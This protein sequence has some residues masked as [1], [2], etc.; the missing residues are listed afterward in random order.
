MNGVG[1]KQALNLQAHKLN[2]R[3]LQVGELLQLEVGVKSSISISVLLIRK[4]MMSILLYGGMR[5][6]VQA[7]IIVILMR[8]YALHVVLKIIRQL[9]IKDSSVTQQNLIWIQMYISG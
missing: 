9:I 8:L 5:V 4:V 2:Q 1:W 3:V 6:M 7:E